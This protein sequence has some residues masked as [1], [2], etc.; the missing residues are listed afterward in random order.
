V[1][2]I[3]L[4]RKWTLGDQVGSGGFGRVFVADDG[5]GNPAVVKFVPKT[6]GADRELLFVKLDGVRNVVPVLDSGEVDG[7]WAIVM[8]RAE[9]SLRQH[10]NDG[11]RLEIG[12]VVAI[13][14]DV[15]TAL[16]D[17][18]GKMV[19]RDLKPENVLLLNDVWCLA[20]FGISRYA[21]ASTA[22]D[23]R[24]F[25]LSPMYAAPERWRGERASISTD[26]Y[27]LG[28]MAHEF[29]NGA[30]PFTGPDVE[31][32]REQHLHDDPPNLDVGP[33]SL[34]AIVAE[35]LYKAPAARPSPSNLLARLQRIGEAASGK[36]LSRLREVHL[37]EVSK[38]SES[39]RLVS[40][41]RTAGER[42]ADLFKSAVPGAKAIERSLLT[43]ISEAAPAAKSVAG[44]RR[45]S[46]L[47]FGKAQLEIF[48]VAEVGPEPWEWDPPAFDVLA[49]AGIVI[50]LPMKDGYCGR[51]HS[52][53]FCNA[54]N[55]GGFQWYETAFMHSPLLRRTSNVR[56][57]MLDPGPDA[58]RAF[59]MGITE[60]Q[61]A[62]P[63][64]PL[65]ISDLHEFID[66]WANW[67][68]DAAEG[69][70]QS[71]RTMP[72]HPISRN[73]RQRS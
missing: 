27:S 36:G 71:P 66:R 31:D 55:A 14:S 45:G 64:A 35:C 2:E 20:D 5:S 29:L 42:R 52:L 56:P 48:P 17:L 43:A 15:T 73:W 68:A 28:V 3:K 21:E 54:G 24:K 60:V 19:H 59:S 4:N 41:K 23:T 34:R 32:Y 8:P 65:D 72:E 50:R 40:E 46:C 63:M 39:E 22:A 37:A 57:F 61:L 26:I 13:L 47:E 49:S 25:A 10:V 53:W 58:A 51:S 33:T 12:S 11:R 9:M 38:R 1:H 6:S 18:D 70:L 67:F 44:M 7:N 69:R 30:R 16:A 62:W